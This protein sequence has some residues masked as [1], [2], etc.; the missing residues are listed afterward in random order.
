MEMYETAFGLILNAGNSKS[1]SMMAIEEARDY[2]FAEAEALIKEAREDLRLAH[3]TQTELIQGE[4]R[5]E[6]QEVSLM[7]VHAQDHLTTAMMMADQAEEF[8]N[9]YRLLS[10]LLKKEDSEWN[11]SQTVSTNHVFL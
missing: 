8:L 1:K 11:T 10:S 7:M 6:K 9:I 3:Q 2:N 4:A 5:G